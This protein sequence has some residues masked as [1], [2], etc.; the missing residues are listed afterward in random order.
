MFLQKTLEVRP[1]VL[2]TALW[3]GSL[4]ILLRQIQ[5]KNPNSKFIKW[6]FLAS[7][8]LLALACIMTQKILF[9]LPGLTITMLWYCF[10]KRSQGLLKERCQNICYQLAGFSFIFILICAY[11]AWHNALNEFFYF[12]FF[13]NAN[14]KLRSF[15]PWFYLE[16][17][18]RQSPFLFTFSSLE[19]LIIIS[20]LFKDRTFYRGDYLLV[21]NYLGLLLGLFIIPAPL[22]QYYL[23]FI[24]LMGLLSA[25]FLVNYIDSLSDLKKKKKS[26]YD[27]YLIANLIFIQLIILI[28]RFTKPYGI[29]DDLRTLIISLVILSL[30]LISLYYKNLAIALLIIILNFPSAKMYTNEFNNTN[31]EQ[32]A[33]ISYILEKTSPNEKI[34]DGWT[35]VGV[36]RPHAYFYW[37]LHQEIR[38]LLTK[39]EKEELLKNLKSGQIKPD[40]ISLDYNLRQISPDITKFFQEN[41][42]HTGQGN[43]HVRK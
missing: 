8:I 28:L 17:L 30:I 35:G 20:R 12:N 24:P 16:K 11:F 19:V 33:N 1:D 2:S 22:R 13:L 14:W 27:I 5:F 29:N 39:E 7:G 38:A 18:I 4:L 43:I 31:V 26:K 6:H 23:M 3:L 41:Y 21:I 10:D 37:M 40:L 9:V 42:Q 25:Q 32:L 34:M 36:F 15:T